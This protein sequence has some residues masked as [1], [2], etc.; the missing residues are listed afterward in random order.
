MFAGRSRPRPPAT[1]HSPMNILL[2]SRELS[3]FFGGGI[4]TYTAEVARALASRGHE[5]H[6]LTMPHDG[7]ARRGRDLF[8]GITPH[9]VD[10]EPGR[11][12]MEA[13]PVSALRHSMAV[14]DSLLDLTRRHRFDLIEFP[15]YHAEG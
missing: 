1:L 10:L 3:P 12:A 4:G 2:V 5:T 11:A 8:P 15:D 7:L 9:S 13:Y 14:P 6:I